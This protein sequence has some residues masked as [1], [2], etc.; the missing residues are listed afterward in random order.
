MSDSVRQSLK[1]LLPLLLLAACRTPR[2]QDALAPRPVTW[3]DAGSVDRGTDRV[4]DR[5]SATAATEATTEAGEKRLSEQETDAST[6]TVSFESTET[7]VNAPAVVASPESLPDATTALPVTVPTTE[8]A[9]PIQLADV[10]QSVAQHY[11]LLESVM[12]ERQ[13]ARGKEVSAWGEFDLGMKAYSVAAPLG[14]YETYR[15]AITFDQPI[16]DGGYVYSGYKMGRGNFEP[17]YKERETN[18]GGEFAAGLGVPL[19][20]NRT[21]D[22]RRS[23]VWQASLA[24]QAVEPAVQAQWL[25]FSRGA[26]QA[27]WSWVAAGRALAAQEFL[28][29]L[30]RER[31]DQ[32]EARV[33]SGDL[34]PIARIDNQRLIAGR[35]TKRVES[36]RK[37]QEASI[38]LSLFYRDAAGRPVRPG[39]ERLPAEFPALPVPDPDQLLA[40]QNAALAARPE[41]RELD[42]VMRQVRVELEQARNQLQPKLDATLGAA[43]DVGG[44]AN[45]YGDKSPFQL[46]AGLV[47]EVPLQRREARG[48]IQ[49]ATGKLAQLQAKREFVVDKTTA[50]VQDA[51]SALLASAERSQL[52]R[53]N[54][55]LARQSLELGRMSFAAGDVDLIVL[56]IYEQAVTDAELI[57]IAARAD[58]FGAMADYDAILARDP[59][60]EW[61]GARDVLSQAVEMEALPMAPPEGPMAPPEGAIAPPEVPVAPPEVTE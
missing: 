15:S 51:Y 58:F 49:A 32:V 20:Q 59:V 13:I 53:R 43:Q 14:Y 61:T 54:V 26:A 39:T 36:Q 6:R 5:S 31:A 7:E 4:A 25:D 50:A 60:S 3:V 45:Y 46:E 35:E 48:K 34:E 9:I 52:A 16:F 47:G 57:E 8:P 23:A 18:E 11:P 38:K 44:K 1:W 42:L 55:E 2:K 12:A 22:K 10:L 37:F 17:W 40:D 19:W 29:S 56:N 24:R 33:Q 21:I 27:Y 28:L 30:A 41:L